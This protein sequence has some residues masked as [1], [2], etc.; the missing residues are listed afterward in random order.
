MNTL[1]NTIGIYADY[2]KQNHKQKIEAVAKAYGY[3]ILYFNDLE[4]VKAGISGCEVL[5]GYY[6]AAILKQA[7]NLRWLATASAGVDTYLSDDVYAHP[8]RI[9]LTNSAG[10]YGTTISEHMLMVILM[11]MRRMP[12]YTALTQK[13][14][15]RN[16]GTVRSI[17]GSRITIVGMG[18]I[19]TNLARRVK[20]LGAAH[21]CGVRRTHKDGDPAFDQVMTLS[22]LSEAVKDVDV[23]ALCVPATQETNGLLSKE[24]I[25][26][27]SPK[28]FVVNVGRGSAIDQP[29][30]VHALNEGRIAGA[31]LDV[32]TP[33][34]L[35]VDDPLYDAKN[36]ILT[37]HISGNMSLGRTCDLNVDMFC[38]NLQRYLEGEPLHHLVNRSIG[39]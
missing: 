18:D 19:G 26:G 34:P 39:Y 14:E 29:A 6:P 23:V 35:P 21:V 15:W 32:M 5:Y 24:I 25:D 4:E 11:L 36:V 31:A 9:Q 30:L 37:P 2:L 1:T 38:R 12:E 3:H 10:S 13:R 17:W 22:Q 7:E 8:E 16:I 27:L 28:T 33:E 20:A